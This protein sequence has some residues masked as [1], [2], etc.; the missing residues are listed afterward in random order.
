VTVAPWKGEGYN[1]RQEV[2]SPNAP[3][4][5]VYIWAFPSLDLRVYRSPTVEADLE[6][7]CGSWRVGA[8]SYDHALTLAGQYLR[9]QWV[10]R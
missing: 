1:R 9:R 5:V 10:Q 4:I 7:T 2:T 6:V 8:R 3:G